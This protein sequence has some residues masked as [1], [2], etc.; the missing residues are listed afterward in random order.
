MNSKICTTLIK[1]NWTLRLNKG[2]KTS[3]DEQN[4]RLDVEKKKTIYV[5]ENF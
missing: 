3:G 2:G 5:E 4:V 1:T